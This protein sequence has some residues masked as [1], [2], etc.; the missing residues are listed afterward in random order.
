M[1]DD[2]LRVCQSKS[3]IA[4]ALGVSPQRLWDYETG[5]RHMPATLVMRLATLANMNSV[6]ALGQ[7][8]AEWAGKKTWRA[9]AGIAGAVFSLAA[10]SV[11]HG[12][13][14]ANTLVNGSRAAHYAQRKLWLWIQRQVKRRTLAAWQGCGGEA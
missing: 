12:N 3:A 2:A 6:G 9:A 13:A 10:L 4:R 5:K 7:Y 14:D 1:I 8:E 11:A